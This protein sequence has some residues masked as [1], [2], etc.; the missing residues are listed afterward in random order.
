MQEFF[1]TLVSIWFIYKL[2]DAFTIKGRSTSA[3]QQQSRPR[4]GEV[5]INESKTNASKFTESEG[6]YVDFEEIKD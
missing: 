5:K 1:F 6:E 3:S 4:E 2:F